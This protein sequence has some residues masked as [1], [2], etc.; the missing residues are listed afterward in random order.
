M[1]HLALFVFHE[2]FNVWR[3]YGE[4][5]SKIRFHFQL[6][7]CFCFE[8]HQYR[9]S[10]LTQVGGRK[11]DQY[12]Q[13]IG[14]KKRVGSTDL[15]P[16][17]FQFHILK[18]I[19]CCRIVFQIQELF[20]PRVWHIINVPLK[21]VSDKLVLVALVFDPRKV[22][23]EFFLQV[24]EMLLDILGYRIRQTILHISSTHSLRARNEE[25]LP[26]STLFFHSSSLATNALIL[27]DWKRMLVPL[28]CSNACKF[29]I[30]L[31]L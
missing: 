15:G 7:A 22:I 25:I 18:G 8:V 28:P 6:V 20:L 11:L 5:T 12:P 26:L 4:R 16:K 19:L 31:L 2:S 21:W 14:R 24:F 3:S 9:K 30:K 27:S 10:C 23:L 1:W 29:I 13:S 17:L